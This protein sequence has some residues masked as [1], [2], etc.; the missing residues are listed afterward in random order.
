[1]A[2]G[3]FLHFLVV[4]KKSQRKKS[5]SWSIEAYEMQTIVFIK[6]SIGTQCV[7]LLMYFGLCLSE[8][9]SAVAAEILWLIEL[10]IFTIWS[11]RGKVCQPLDL[12]DVLQILSPTSKIVRSE[13]GL[14]LVQCLAQSR[15]C[16][17]AESM[18]ECR[19]GRPKGRRGGRERG[20]E[21][22][23]IRKPPRS[24]EYT[25]V[26]RS[27]LFGPATEHSL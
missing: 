8:P 3:F 19:E 4:E 18:S 24:C 11:L 23:E 5:I 26:C 17:L 10:K 20:E 15:G 1:M 12:N 14:F 21:R 22:E 13:Q 25:D 27:L 7:H 16:G 2:W 6:R 9:S